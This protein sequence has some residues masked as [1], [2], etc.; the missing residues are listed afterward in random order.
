MSNGH[1]ISYKAVTLL[2]SPQPVGKFRATIVAIRQVLPV[3]LG[4]I[5]PVRQIV[6]RQ[7]ARDHG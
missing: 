3:S 7:N 6:P 4:R 1:A 5:F 2:I